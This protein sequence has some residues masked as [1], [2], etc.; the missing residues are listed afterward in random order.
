[1][2]LSTKSRYAVRILANIAAHQHEGPVQKKRVAEQEYLSADYVEQILVALRHANIV[3][4][5]RGAKGG[6]VTARPPAEI[7]VAEVI[8]ATEGPLSLAPCDENAKAGREVCQGACITRP[9]WNRAAEMLKQ[10]F[11]GID[12]GQLAKQYQ[13]Q[14]QQGRMYY[15]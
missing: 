9:I 14:E 1:M 12:M 15:I 4:S 7:S 3:N 8:E 10:Y 13:E 5:R 2:Q 11:S 6:F